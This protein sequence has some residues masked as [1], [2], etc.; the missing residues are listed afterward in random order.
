MTNRSVFLPVPLVGVA[1]LV[2]GAFFAGIGVS[3]TA[4]AD[5]PRTALCKSDFHAALNPT[6]ISTEIQ[7]WMTEQIAAG[8]TQFMTQP[9]GGLLN[10]CA[11]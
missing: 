9:V 2:A 4:Q 11:W 6:K 3:H 7:D 8:R 5:V 10:I 1:L